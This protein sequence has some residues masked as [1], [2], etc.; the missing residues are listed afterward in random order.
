VAEVVRV[1]VLELEQLGVVERIAA[2]EELPEV[3]RR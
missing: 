1:E 2:G 3:V